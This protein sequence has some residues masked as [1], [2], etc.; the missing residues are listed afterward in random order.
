HGCAFAAAGVQIA[1]PTP[2]A[3]STAALR[4]RTAL[5]NAPAGSSHATADATV[6]ADGSELPARFA[7]RHHR[8]RRPQPGHQAERAGDSLAGGARRLRKSKRTRVRERREIRV[9]RWRER[10]CTERKLCASLFW[11]EEEPPCQPE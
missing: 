5:S 10:I 9:A 6:R 8:A 4:S 11:S 3:R 2:A 1:L 7:R